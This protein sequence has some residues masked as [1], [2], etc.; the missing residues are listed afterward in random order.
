MQQFAHAMT[1]M[2]GG[3]ANGFANGTLRNGTVH[4]GTLPNGTMANG[5]AG[6]ANNKVRALGYCPP[7]YLQSTWEVLVLFLGQVLNEKTGKLIVS[8]CRR[9]LILSTPVE[10]QVCC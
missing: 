1:R 8:D 7:K 2:G 5:F 9:L 10:S 4:N 6:M 3:M